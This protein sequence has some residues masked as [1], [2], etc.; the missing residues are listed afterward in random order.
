MDPETQLLWQRSQLRNAR[1]AH[2]EEHNCHSRQLVSQL[3][4]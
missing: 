3:A 4:Y 2:N 1:E